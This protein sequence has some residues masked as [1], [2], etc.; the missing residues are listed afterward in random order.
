MPVITQMNLGNALANAAQDNLNKN[1]SASNL[2][3]KLKK[4][5]SL[6]DSGLINQQ[7]FEAKKTKLLEDL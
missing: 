6:L 1:T 7:D 5:K 2:E 4:L 3:T